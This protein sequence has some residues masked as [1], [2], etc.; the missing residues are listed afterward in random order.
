MVNS[1]IKEIMYHVL[2]VIATYIS[3]DLQFHLINV[4]RIIQ[5]ILNEFM[6]ENT[7]ANIWRPWLFGDFV[8]LKRFKLHND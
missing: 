8:I 5:C 6:G 4:L 3:F 2:H 7:S 1:N